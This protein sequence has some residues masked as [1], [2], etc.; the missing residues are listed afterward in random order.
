MLLISTVLENY[1]LGF[2]KTQ[3]LNNYLKSKITSFT[4]DD[5]FTVPERHPSF[6]M[7]SRLRLIFAQN[8]TA[9]SGNNY[10]KNDT[11]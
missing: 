7:K 1:V 11:D 8:F 3:K 6:Y 4:I 9:G 5:Y 2:Y 10:Y